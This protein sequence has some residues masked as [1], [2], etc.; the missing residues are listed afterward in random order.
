MKKIKK[1][2]VC[3][4]K[5]NFTLFSVEGFPYFTAPVKKSSKAVITHRYP[6]RRLE[7]TLSPVV[8]KICA[9]IYLRELP[10]EKLIS[11]LYRKYYSYPSAMMGSFVPER[12]NE[13]LRLFRGRISK[14]L[15]AKAPDVYEIGCYD[16]YIL[17]NLK[18]QGYLVR[19]CDPSDGADIGKKFGLKIDKEFFDHKKHAERQAKHDTVISRHFFEHLHDPVGFLKGLT[20]VLKTG[21]KIVFEVPNALFAVKNGNPSVFSFQHLQYFSPSSA[22]EA[23]KRAGLRL[24]GLIDTGENLIVV[25]GKQGVSRQGEAKKTVVL[26]RDFREKLE[27]NVKKFGRLAG[28]YDGYVIWGAGGFTGS[29]IKLFKIPENKVRFVV[30]SDPKKWGMQFLK[31]DFDIKSPE[32]VRGLGG[33]MIISSMY[34]GQIMQKLKMLGYKGDVICLYPEV[35]HIYGGGNG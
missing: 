28:K 16:G 17:Y 7:D 1:C 26:C 9:H 32:A 27:K 35:R 22:A 5:E 15:A 19:G 3:G 8:C 25:C 12:D 34:A 4:G 31:N 24:N 29:A 23:V 14:M 10:D 33:C 20:K 13:F 18:K 2:P 11:E 30:D 21:G 6:L